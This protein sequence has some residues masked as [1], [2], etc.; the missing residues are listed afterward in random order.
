MKAYV[1]VTLS[2]VR[3]SS[4][5]FYRHGGHAWPLSL[6][7]TS[8]KWQSAKVMALN[9]RS[10]LWKSWHGVTRSSFRR[11]E[12][13]PSPNARWP[14]KECCLRVAGTHQP[15]TAFPFWMCCSCVANFVFQVF[16]LFRCRIHPG[17]NKAWPVQTWAP[18]E[19][20]VTILVFFSFWKEKKAHLTR[21]SKSLKIL[22][23][24]IYENWKKKS[25]C[26]YVPYFAHVN[27]FIC[28][29]FRRT[30]HCCDTA[31]VMET[32]QFAVPVHDKCHSVGPAVL[33]LLFCVCC[34]GLAVSNFQIISSSI[35]LKEAHKT[36][37]FTCSV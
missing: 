9:W 16:V 18:N 19:V 14:T 33:F 15:R 36:Q 26:T 22:P 29:F 13:G 34:V 17:D 6:Y 32:G 8:S 12:C 25:S 7:L 23:K 28:I 10:S 30:R 4:P 35:C 11:W 5:I 2:C 27:V 21:V 31:F 24:W 37:G 20:R 1:A 3:W